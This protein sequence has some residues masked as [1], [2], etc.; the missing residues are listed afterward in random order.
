MTRL[1]SDDR[2]PYCV[3][4]RRGFLERPGLRLTLP[5]AQRLWA[6]GPPVCEQALR[7]LVR[8]GFV[9][10]TTDDE[11][12]RPSYTTCDDACCHNASDD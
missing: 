12:C 4:I 6:L 1:L 7:E 2:A 11:Y 3:D 8:Q 5:E 10:R 9:V